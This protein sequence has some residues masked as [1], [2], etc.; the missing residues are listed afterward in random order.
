KYTAEALQANPN[1]IAADD[2][3]LKTPAVL[4]I[5]GRASFDLAPKAKEIKDKLKEERTPAKG[6]LFATEKMGIGLPKAVLEDFILKKEVTSLKLTALRAFAEPSQWAS[7]HHAVCFIQMDVVGEITKVILD[8]APKPYDVAPGIT[9]VWK[10]TAPGQITP[11]G[12][13][14]GSLGENHA[15][16][17]GCSQPANFHGDMELW[18]SCFS[19]GHHTGVD[20][21]R[22]PGPTKDTY[23]IGLYPR[24]T[25]R[26]VLTVTG[27]GD[28]ESKIKAQIEFGFNGAHPH[29][30]D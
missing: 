7:Y 13:I 12:M 9:G 11:A 20:L 3:Y 16:N 26:C 18:G 28:W 15:P 17:A 4:D 27:T 5:S 29:P 2:L 24:A 1:L 21:K 25:G 8:T 22:Q 14:R 23:V 10:P 19:D 30:G 6:G